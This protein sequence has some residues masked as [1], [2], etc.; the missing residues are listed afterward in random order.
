M[1]TSKNNIRTENYSIN[2]LIRDYR[3]FECI[4]VDSFS[5]LFKANDKRTG[6]FVTLLFLR[7]LTKECHLRKDFVQ[8]FTTINHLKHPLIL[9]IRKAYIPLDSSTQNTPTQPS[10]IRNFSQFKLNSIITTDFIENGQL[11]IHTKRYLRL[12]GQNNQKLNP[13]I[14]SKVIFGIA[15]LMQYLHSLKIQ[16]YSLKFEKIYLNEKFEP[17]F[18]NVGFD[19]FN[20]KTIK[21]VE[22]IPPLDDKD[23]FKGEIYQFAIFIYKMFS[24]EQLVIN[25][26]VV[27]MNYVFKIK[28]GWR[29][30]KPELMP[31]CYWNLV[32]RC[33]DRNEVKRPSFDEIVQIL[34]NDCFAI[35]EFGMKT[36]RD[37]L[38]RYQLSVKNKK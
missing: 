32:C 35:D 4:G 16:A 34:Q 8:L 9:P 12:K 25:K 24:L 10:D 5:A 21:D 7:G 15:S 33:W 2:D 30:E 38:H 13:T 31:D 14:R 20:N 28:N 36:D 6:E 18:I 23:E 26:H 37:E 11:S 3:V 17:I 19:Y 22:Y 27:D 29:P 1:I